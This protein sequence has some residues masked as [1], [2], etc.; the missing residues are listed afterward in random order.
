MAKI[1]TVNVRIPRKVVDWLDSL[2]R[3][4][5]YKSRSEAIRAI[6]REYVLSEEKAEKSVSLEDERNE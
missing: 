4:G 1:E 6:L 3:E 2:I 5:L